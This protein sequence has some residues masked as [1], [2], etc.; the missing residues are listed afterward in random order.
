M[1]VTDDRVE[2][3]PAGRKQIAR[4]NRFAGT[5]LGASRNH[6][7]CFRV[8]WDDLQTPDVIHKKFLT[9]LAK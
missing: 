4:G 8:K 3:T 2:L 7:D 6:E 1:F 5:V 9:L